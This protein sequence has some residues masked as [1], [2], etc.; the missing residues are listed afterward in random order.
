MA[1]H[2]LFF[3]KFFRFSVLF[4]FFLCGADVIRKQSAAH[5]FKKISFAPRTSR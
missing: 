3:G 4:L 5:A 1:R 2:L